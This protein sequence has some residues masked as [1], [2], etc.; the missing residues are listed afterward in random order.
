[1]IINRVFLSQGSDSGGPFWVAT[2]N[3]EIANNGQCQAAGLA[4]DASLNVYAIAQKTDNFSVWDLQLVKFTRTGSID[5]Q[6]KFST[7]FQWFL[8]TQTGGGRIQGKTVSI[9]ASGNVYLR[10]RPY[11]NPQGQWGSVRINS[12]ATQAW[13]R[14]TPDEYSRSG[15]HSLNTSGLWYAVTSAPNVMVRIDYQSD[16]TSLYR[17]IIT[18]PNNWTVRSYSF[19]SSGSWTSLFGVI[20]RSFNGNYIF[21]QIWNSTTNYT[22]Q[23]WGVD[24]NAGYTFLVGHDCAMDSGLA[25]IMVGRDGGGFGDWVVKSPFL[26]PSISWSRR[27][28]SCQINQVVV[29]SAN[30]VL[31]AG[32][33]LSGGSIDGVFIAKLDTNG[34]VQWQRRMT[35]S[36]YSQPSAFNLATDSIG[37]IYLG[38]NGYTTTGNKSPLI[39]AKLPGDGTLTGTYGSITYA[40]HSATVNTNNFLIDVSGESQSG[41]T[42]TQSDLANNSFTNGFTT[43]SLTNSVVTLS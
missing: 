41:L 1:M 6:N 36:G 4:V 11:S 15:F 35:I 34:T 23:I 37:N 8:D 24:P 40:S 14:I 5:W 20:D 38:I 10:Y 22:H 39:V 9:D 33:T 13:S 26:S 7:G 42:V 12:A 16:G 18:N 31:V 21:R 3:A 25:T 17:A 30:N 2:Y 32:A 27:F 43:T 19:A 28:S 29:D